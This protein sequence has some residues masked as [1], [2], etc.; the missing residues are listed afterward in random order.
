MS[1]VHVWSPQPFRVCLAPQVRQEPWDSGS[2][3]PSSDCSACE[4]GPQSPH[5]CEE[6]VGSVSPLGL[7]R[8]DP[9]EDSQPSTAQHPGQDTEVKRHAVALGFYLGFA[10]VGEGVGA[11]VQLASRTPRTQEINLVTRVYTPGETGLHQ[12]LPQDT[13]PTRVQAPSFWQ[14]RGPPE[15]PCRRRKDLFTSLKRAAGAPVCP[16]LPPRRFCAGK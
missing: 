16:D 9:S 2:A 3:A 7:H 11:G 10:E 13:L 8:G 4:L 1:W 6:R 12:S 5:L 15:S 14:T